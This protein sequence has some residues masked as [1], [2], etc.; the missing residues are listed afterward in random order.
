MFE[1][2]FPHTAAIAASTDYLHVRWSSGTPQ[3]ASD[4]RG[5]ACRCPSPLDCATNHLSSPNGR[6]EKAGGAS[7]KFDIFFIKKIAATVLNKMFDCGM[8][9]FRLRHDPLSTAA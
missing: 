8:I 9:P 5:R 4:S 3:R 1:G 6:F 2:I 7:D